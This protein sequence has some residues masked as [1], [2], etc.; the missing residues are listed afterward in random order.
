MKGVKLVE[1]RQYEGSKQDLGV[2]LDVGTITTITKDPNVKGNVGNGGLYHSIKFW[3]D[4][5]KG[6]AKAFGDTAKVLQ[7]LVE[8]APVQANGRPL[9]EPVLI[10]GYASESRSKPDSDGNVSYFDMEI[11]IEGVYEAPSITKALW[12]YPQ[13]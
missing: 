12:S 2:F 13:E 5:F 3:G 1:L 6:K 7:E 9:T 10:K 4:K 8:N 11:Y